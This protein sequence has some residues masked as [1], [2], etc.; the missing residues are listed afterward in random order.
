[1]TFWKERKLSVISKFLMSQPG[2]QSITIHILPISLSQEVKATKQ[3][4]LVSSGYNARNTVFPKS[5]RK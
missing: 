1:M 4:N 2:K 5:F 3:C